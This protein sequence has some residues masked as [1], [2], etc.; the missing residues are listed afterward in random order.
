MTTAL[1]RRPTRAAAQAG[2]EAQPGLALLRLAQG[3]GESARAA[4]RRALE[5]TSAPLERARLLPAAVEL[6]LAAGDTDGAAAA[7]AELE[8]IAATLRRELLDALVAHARGAVALARGEAAQALAALRDAGRR[9]RELEMPYEAARSREL[10]GVACRELGDEDAAAL[11]LG[12]ARDAF[13]ALGA[14]PDHLRLAAPARPHGLTDREMEVLRHVAAG[15]TNRAIAAALVLSERTVDRHVSNIFAKLGVP[16]RTA[17]A[18]YA[19]E[20][21]LV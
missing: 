15:A 3:R 9:W 12:A 4:L 16:S 10:A 7:C 5:E 8:R 2:A 11:E 17:A 1:P 19:Y 6:R 21:R 14:M 18:A 20:H 13:A